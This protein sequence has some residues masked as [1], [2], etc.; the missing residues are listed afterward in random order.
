VGPGGQLADQWRGRHKQACADAE[1]AG[2]KIRQRVCLGSCAGSLSYGPVTNR[3][4]LFIMVSCACSPR[5][6]IQRLC[7]LQRMHLKKEC[8][9]RLTRFGSPI[10]DEWLERTC[11]QF[12]FLF[13]R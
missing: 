7:T 6:P 13:Q 10:L 3:V 4:R 8:E 5:L 9:T 11:L 2:E 1:Q 12:F